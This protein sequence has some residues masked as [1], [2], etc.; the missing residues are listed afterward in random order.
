MAK[1]QLTVNGKRVTID[2]DDPDMPLL[3]ALRDNLALHGPRFGC[4]LAQCGS[5]TVH[6]DGKSV[7]SCVTPLSSLNANQKVVTLEGLGTP[8]K[9]H[10]VQQ[11]FIDEQAAQCGY[12]IN[13]MIME[14]AAFLASNKKPSDAQIRQALA[15]NL[16]RCGTHDRIVKAVKRASSMA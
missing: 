10:P 7:R 4:G 6:V 3:Y 5:C 13:G 15:N 11:A 8:N 16:C 14:S 1:K 2:I 9:P 12:C